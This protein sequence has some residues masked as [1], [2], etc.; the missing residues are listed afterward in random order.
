MARKGLNTDHTARLLDPSSSDMEQEKGIRVD[1]I[2]AE[3]GGQAWEEGKA[4]YEHIG[5]NRDES[6]HVPWWRIILINGVMPP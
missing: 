1:M 3:S 4:V 5:E 6:A 2:G